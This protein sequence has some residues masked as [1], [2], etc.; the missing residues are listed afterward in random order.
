MIYAWT[1]CLFPDSPWWLTVWPSNWSS[2]G[3]SFLLGTPLKSHRTIPNHTYHFPSLFPFIS[4][5]I[6]IL[7]CIDPRKGLSLIIWEQGDEGP[8][9]LMLGKR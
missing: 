9:G 2:L 4:L 5:Y 7:G 8:E 3:M 6:E 1:L